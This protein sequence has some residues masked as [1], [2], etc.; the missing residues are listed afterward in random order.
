[1]KNYLER[2]IADPVKE[3]EITA[4][5][6]RLADHATPLYS[7]KLALA[8]P[9]SGFRSVGIVLLRAEVKEVSFSFSF[10]LLRCL[11]HIVRFYLLSAGCRMLVIT[12]LCWRFRDNVFKSEIGDKVF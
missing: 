2:K 11:L 12:S 10:S 4:V 9:T 6:I 3:I 8:S 1:L 5:G 7:Q